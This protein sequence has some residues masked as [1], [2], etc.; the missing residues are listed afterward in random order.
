MANGVQTGRLK[1]I[2]ILQ[3]EL[4]HC[5]HR[6]QLLLQFCG[7]LKVAR[8]YEQKKDNNNHYLR[9][10]K[11]YTETAVHYS[12]HA[13]VTHAKDTRQAELL[14]RRLVV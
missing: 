1:I 6:Q 14:L 4:G 8:R 9:K 12:H 10:R 11:E 3:R 5:L 7:F 13:E 2:N